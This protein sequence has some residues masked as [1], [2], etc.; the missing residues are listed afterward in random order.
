MFFGL[1]LSHEH[2]DLY[3]VIL[4]VIGHA[5]R[6]KLGMFDEVYSASFINAIGSGVQNSVWVQTSADIPGKHNRMRQYSRCS[7]GLYI[8]VRFV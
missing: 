4:K 5:V 6:H 7:F 2:S 8:F 3:R 1:N